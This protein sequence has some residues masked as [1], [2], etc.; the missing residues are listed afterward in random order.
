[1]CSK[2]KEELRKQKKLG[3]LKY[4]E[5]G[6]KQ[7]TK[8]SIPWPQVPSV[9]NRTPGWWAIP[10][11]EP[12]QIFWS[13]AHDVRYL[14]RFSEKPLLCDCRIYFLSPQRG[15]DPK[16]LAAALNSS[17]SSLFLEI[18]GRVSLGEGA[19]DVMVEDAQEYMMVP[20]IFGKSSPTVLN[21]FNKLLNRPIKPISEEALMKDR[22]FLD[23]AVLETA[24]LDPKKF[25][26]P[27]Y[28]A[29]IELSSERI[30]L[31]KLRKKLRN[32]KYQRDIDKPAGNSGEC[33]DYPRWLQDGR[34][35]RGGTGDWRR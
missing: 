13:K 4:I 7:T 34:E 32:S 6:E 12:S 10:D 1:M 17:L 2:S 9:Q 25:L 8:E 19:L 21:A 26:K 14:H 28:D 16:L 23:R 15:I 29:L 22:Q 33:G 5:W 3:A 18:I 24:G 27:I 11:L 30:A 31:A 20:N 35:W